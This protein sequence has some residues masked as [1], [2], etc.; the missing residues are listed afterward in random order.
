MKR[1][2]A[3]APLSRDHHAALILSRLL[4]ADAPAYK[5]LPVEPAEKALYA[6]KVYKEELCPHF[7]TEEAAMN[8]LAGL[9]PGLDELISRIFY[10]HGELHHYF[11]VIKAGECSPEFLDMLGKY[12]EL[13]IRKEERQLFPLIQEKA[14]EAFLARLEQITSK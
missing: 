5:T 13:H 10:E 14:G 8:L 9:D 6:Y 3:L 2:P 7:S 4:Q 12:L 11:S 1:H